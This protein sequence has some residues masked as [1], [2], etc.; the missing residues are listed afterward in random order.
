MIVKLEIIK[1]PQVGR[2]F[3][4]TEPDTFLVGRAKD[5]HFHLPEDDPFVSRRHFH[6]EIIPPRC[7]FRDLNSK[8]TP[9]V[10]DMITVE[11]E[12]RDQDVIEVGYTKLRVIIS[13]KIE[14]QKVACKRCRNEITI[15]TNETPPDNCDDCLRA[16]EQ[17]KRQKQESKRLTVRCQCGKD[18]SKKAN[19]DG[20]AG[21]LEGLV[22]YSCPRCLPKGDK[23]NGKTIDKYEIIRCIGEG[24]MGKAYLVYHKSTARILVAKKMTGLINRDLVRRFE[25]EIRFLTELRHPHIIRLIDSGVQGK[26]PYMV[27]EYARGG[28]LSSLLEERDG[29]LTIRQAVTHIIES[30]KGLEFIHSRNL[31][32]R[33]IKPENILMQKTGDN[34]LTA[35]LTDFGLAKK[36]NEAGGSSFTRVGVALG[37]Q[38]YMSPE[39][40]KD[41]KNVKEPADLYSMGVSLYYLLTA[42][43]PFNFPTPTDILAVMQKY[44][45]RF[46]N[47]DE[48]FQYLVG[49]QKLKNP[50]M[51]ILTE[52]PIP[53]RERNPKI[54]G[55]LAAIVDR[56]I[57]K[58][59][60]Q[61]YQSAGSFRKA[62]ETVISNSNI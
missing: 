6:L 34:N 18:L 35:K 47:A 11:T 15:V 50:M 56:S 59:I 5:A 4:F 44:R 52:E 21:E 30:L 17:E 16:I 40:I 26:E 1:G 13:D 10:N 24:G 38:L 19:S 29:P 43:Y 3:S 58:P 8:N 49:K 55:D 32:H 53:V 23:E 46:R 36:Y 62:L 60:S 9:K 51:I 27:M 2:T 61:R 22:T 28:D 14:T 37:T 7:I 25:R 12:L 54:P 42:R 48:A 41:A 20:R 33:D 31:I 39:Q 45:D 57:K